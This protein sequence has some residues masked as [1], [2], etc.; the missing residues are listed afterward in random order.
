MADSDTVSDESV[1]D[2]AGATP[3]SSSADTDKGTFV[4][5]IFGGAVACVLGF[6]AG[7]LDSVERALGWAPEED[8]AL[9]QV[10]EAQADTI[11]DQSAQ[12][13]ELTSRL[14]SLPPPPEP[15]DLSG[16]EGGLSEQSSA[17]VDVTNRLTEL[18]KRPM[19]ENVSEDAIAAYEAELARLRKTVDAQQAEVQAMLD[20]ARNTETLA[21]K[22][23]QIALARAAMTRIVAAVDSGTPFAD[24]VADLQAASNADVPGAL[25]AQADDG[26]PTL[27]QLQSAFPDAARAA[28]AAA[29]SEGSG[30]G[31]GGLGGFLERQLGARSTTPQEGDSADAVLSRA[32]AAVRE[33]R[34]G[35]ALAE[36]D[37]LS[38]FAKA[39][40][41][42]WYGLAEARRDATAAA[43]ELMIML[44]SN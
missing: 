32:E 12:I 11:R 20:D 38:D 35:D 17:L 9:Q 14:D 22:N 18:E 19:T 24:A 26:V 7:Q 13:L 37:T 27:A 33:G 29:R 10:V 43:D 2:S 40:L 21:E 28:L 44:S 23:A 31:S 1:S 5:L 36:T 3:S 15:V 42:D 39:T 6:F 4:P 16:L 8:N 34:I 30:D 41:A 25:L